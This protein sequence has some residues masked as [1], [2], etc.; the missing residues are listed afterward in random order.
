MIVDYS[1]IFGQ[2]QHQFSALERL[3][4]L[5]IQSNIDAPQQT[6]RDDV[7]SISSSVDAVEFGFDLS[8]ICFHYKHRMSLRNEAPV[9]VLG[10]IISLQVKDDA[11]SA[12]PHLT[13]FAR[14]W[15]SPETH[16]KINISPRSSWSAQEQET[17]NGP[18]MCIVV[19]SFSQKVEHFYV[20]LSRL[21]PWFGVSN[22]ARK[23]YQVREAIE[24]P[25]VDVTVSSL[26][27]QV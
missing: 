7:L 18:D 5:L 6:Q 21:K 15:Q 14:M 2:R 17:R 23:V 22:D 9:F 26:E 12:V 20:D 25:Q 19:T 16:E 24:S 1:E 3:G 4:P 10:E 8:K 13:A 27:L 11:D